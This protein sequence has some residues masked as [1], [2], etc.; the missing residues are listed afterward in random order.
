MK[1]KSIRVYLFM[2]FFIAQLV[3]AQG[4]KKLE[5]VSSKEVS[6]IEVGSR[7]VGIEIHKSFPMI[8]R[9]SFYYPVANSIDISEDYW[10][11]E[12]YRIMSMGIKVGD[13]PKHILENEVYRVTQS[14]YAVEFYKEKFNSDIDIKYEFCMNSPALVATFQIKNNSDSTKNYEIY[15]HYEAVLRTSHTYALMDKANTSIEGEGKVV[16]VNYDTVG[17]GYAQLF[18]ANAGLQPEYY[19]SNSFAGNYTNLNEYWLNTDGQ[20]EN[21]ELTESKKGKPAA[22]FVYKKE[23]KP[24]ENLDHWF[25][26]KGRS[27]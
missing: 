27:K 16:K 17:T 11:R 2:F 25:V 19:T 5:I 1:A 7:Y 14:P 18:F 26:Q 24:G 6:Q 10:K 13:N 23:L 20:F 8:N 3:C 9:I 21:I 22:A 12:N 15:T 4:N